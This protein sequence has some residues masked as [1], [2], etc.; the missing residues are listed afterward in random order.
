M[1]KTIIGI[2]VTA[3]ALSI[4]W[5]A[6]S[7]GRSVKSD[8][9]I[10]R[11]FHGRWKTEYYLGNKDM[12]MMVRETAVFDT[13]THRYSITQVQELIS[14]VNIVYANVSYEG[15]WHAD[16]KFLLGKIDS[17]TVVNELNPQFDEIPEY[18]QYLNFVEDE[19]DADLESD[20]FFIRKLEEGRI[21]LFDEDRDVAHDLIRVQPVPE[22]PDHE[23]LL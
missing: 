16:K 22:D 9:E 5:V 11:Q 13:L 12:R 15:T 1:K 19:A 6:E 18:R 10:E 4:G 3:G 20:E 2:L 23:I 8:P 7:C 14:P 21:H 17:K